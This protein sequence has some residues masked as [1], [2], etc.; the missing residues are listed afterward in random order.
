MGSEVLAV[1]ALPHDAVSDATTMS[2]HAT[3]R[4]NFIENMR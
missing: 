3:R 1:D 4:E 2:E